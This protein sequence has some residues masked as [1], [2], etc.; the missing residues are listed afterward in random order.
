MNVYEAI[1]LRSVRSERIAL[2]KKMATMT[3]MAV[4]ETAITT[5]MDAPLVSW[6]KKKATLR[7]H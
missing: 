7:R 4:K 6:K 3:M 5:R 1:M 2:K